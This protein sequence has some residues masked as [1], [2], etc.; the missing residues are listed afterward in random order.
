MLNPPFS[1]SDLPRFKA[2]DPVKIKPEISTLLEKNKQKI[3]GLLSS[4]GPFTWDNLMQP[5]EDLSDELSKIWSPISHLHAVMESDE[6]RKAYNE[7][8]PLITEYHTQLSQ[9]EKL[10]QAIQS[11]IR[12]PDFE[13]LSP[14]QKKIIEN[15]LRDFR[16]AG[17]HLPADQKERMA[18]LQKELTQLMTKYSENV[19]DA[20]Q[21]WTL[22]IT[23]PYQLEGLP[24]QALQ[25][26][27]D[28]AK[29]R[30]L[31]GY[32]FTLDYPSY[33]TAV[34][35][36]RD[37]ELRKQL[38]EAY[39]TRAS[40]QGPMAGK[41]DNTAIMEKILKVRHEIAQLVG[42]KNYAEYSL[43]TKMA[44]TPDEVL[45]FLHDLLIRSKA[46]AE[47]EYEEVRQLAKSLDNLSALEIWDVSYYS[48]KLQELKFKFS[49]EDFRPYFPIQKVLDGMFTLVNKLYGIHI[50]EEKNIE[51]WH[52][53]VRFFSIHDDKNELRGGFYIDLYARPHKRDGAWMDECRVRRLL[54]GKGIQHPIAYLTCNFMPPVDGLPG[55]LT[56]DDVLTLFHEFGHCLHHMLTKVDYPSVAGINGVPWDAVEFPSQFM[57][58]YCWEKE[59]LSLISGHYETGEPLPDELYQKMIAA[60]HFQTGLQM[61]RQLEFAIF[62]F[63]LHLE[64]DPAKSGE[65]EPQTQL[66]LNDVRKNTSV[67]P[68]PAFNR[69]Q[70]SFSHVFAGS[71][72]AGYYSYK[73]AEV[74]SSDAYA[75]FE[76]QGIFDRKTGRAFMENILEM[77]GVRDPMSAFIAFR[78]REPTIDAL[79]KQNGITKRTA[80]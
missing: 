33:S 32:V 76:E 14:A 6:L 52:P 72:A 27:I 73:W 5:L 77:G 18:T 53:H 75:K 61:V 54:D 16:L 7:T 3:N 49:Q 71:Y 38:Y 45:H 9:N 62:D 56:H 24:P 50:R 4:A 70:H 69:F 17:V 79:L 66:I 42:F 64:Y 58:N 46:I 44:K 47:K 23:D 74:L 31:E 78:G 63:R 20:T 1:Q 11:L 55:L 15:D 80:A 48:E 35:F 60:K 68:V 10:F 37:R 40:D 43:A 36:L 30:G 67:I 28:N 26:A 8:V 21:S 19:M 12:S 65:G 2:I 29:R 22:H 59:S 41:W 13:M 39:S 25:L 34:R 51:V 57:E